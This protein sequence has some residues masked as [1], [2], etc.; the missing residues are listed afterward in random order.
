MCSGDR[1]SANQYSAFKDV[2]AV[3]LL[4]S[5]QK[6]YLASQTT[7]SYCHGLLL[8]HWV[9]FYI[10]MVAKMEFDHIFSMGRV[11]TAQTLNKKTQKL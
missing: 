1:I 7:V 11:I 5:T 8:K 9:I 3:G 10:S 4:N 6:L 2:K